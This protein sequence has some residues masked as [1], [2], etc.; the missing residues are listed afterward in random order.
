MIYKIDK[1]SSFSHNYSVETVQWY[2]FDT[3]IFITSGMDKVLKI[4]DTKVMEPAENLKFKGRIFQHHL[5]PV[6]SPASCLIAAA[7]TVNKALLVDI[8]SGSNVYELRGHTSSVLSCKW[9]PSTLYMLATGSADNKIMLWDVRAT[10]NCLKVLDQNNGK[11]RSSCERTCTAHDGSVN[12]LCFTR[13]GLNLLSFGTDSR[14]RLWNVSTGENEMI[15]YGSIPNDTRKSAQ[16]DVSACTNKDLVYI[17]SEG[18]ILIYS[19]YT[20]KK[21][22]A[23]PGHYSTVNCCYFHPFNIQLYSGGNDRIILCWSDETVESDYEECKKNENIIENEWS[24]S[25]ED[26]YS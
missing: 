4:W 26:S 15:N 25:D 21:I 13:N 6:P 11:G 7:T 2:P 12:G 8:K 3:G 14:L 17:P 1:S 22:K 19:L 9:S 5:C 16:I 10:K 23:L 18:N 20:G 24:T